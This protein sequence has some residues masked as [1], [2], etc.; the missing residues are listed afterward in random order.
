ME[1]GIKEVYENAEERLERINFDIRDYTQKYYQQKSYIEEL[2]EK[3]APLKKERVTLQSQLDL[4]D[5]Q[6]S[7]ATKKIQNVEIQVN[8]KRLE[9][10][11]L[12][13]TIERAEVEIEEEKELVF[14]FIRKMYAEERQ[15]FSDYTATPE[16]IKLLLSEKS[17]SESLQ[18]I[19]YL[20]VMEELGR[21]V[22]YRLE[23]ANQKF[24]EKKKALEEK[25]DT[26]NALKFILEQEKANLL[27]QKQG[28][29]QLFNQ[30]KGQE[31][32]YQRLIAESK[33]QE[34]EAL[35]AIANLK[36]NQKAIEEKLLVF[37]TDSPV[38]VQEKQKEVLREVIENPVTVQKYDLEG[39]IEDIAFSAP[40]TW[41]VSPDRGITAYF[42]DDSYE[43]YFGVEH[44]AIDIRAAQGTTIFAPASAYV[45]KVADNGMGYSYIILA[46][47]NGISTLYG[48][49][50]EFNVEEGQLIQ[51]GTAIGKTG[52]TP[53]TV[54]AGTRT[55]GPHLHL[56]VFEDGVQK[57]PLDFLPIELLPK[58]YWR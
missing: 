13:E 3:I 30:T 47:K 55:T 5:E 45:E 12:Q 35:L 7:L 46:H 29:E 21:Q 8:Q 43:A 9:I 56:E 52:G 38:A 20:G 28:K 4:F 54:G 6:I 58:E 11:K 31:D 41:P 26:L 16:L 18:E 15:L 24:F 23:M 32:E 19:E 14:E 17:V 22:F 34:E 48:H 57:D 40:L 53:G 2:E 51:M 37:D 42:D 49:I 44:K 50:S 36:E 10:A 27:A 1:Q 33:Q 39:L 25:T